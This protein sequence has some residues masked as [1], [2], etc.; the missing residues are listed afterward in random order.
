MDLTPKEKKLPPDDEPITEEDLKS[1]EAAF[2]KKLRK[3]T[4]IQE[5]SWADFCTLIIECL[6]GEVLP[7]KRSRKPPK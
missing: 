1:Y 5:K 3:N 4:E 6:H 7:Q 2:E